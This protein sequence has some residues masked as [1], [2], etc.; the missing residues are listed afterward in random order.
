MKRMTVLRLKMSWWFT[1]MALSVMPYALLA[2]GVME[3]FITRNSK[4][5]Q[6]WTHFALVFPLVLCSYLFLI[7]YVDAC[8]RK[9][10]E[11]ELLDRVDRARYVI[12]QFT[13]G[14]FK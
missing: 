6:E 7:A 9:T 1:C 14:L 5:F 11:K 13:F 3:F 8:T 2:H 12:K 10:N 4:E